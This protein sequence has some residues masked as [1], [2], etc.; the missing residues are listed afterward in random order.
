MQWKTVKSMKMTRKIIGEAAAIKSLN[1]VSTWN[2]CYQGDLSTR[3]DLSSNPIPEADIRVLM[4]H[5]QFAIWSWNP[6]HRLT[7][8]PHYMKFCVSW[9]RS[10]S[11]LSRSPPNWK[12]WLVQS[13]RPIS[14]ISRYIWK[15]SMTNFYAYKPG[16]WSWEKALR[17]S[18][19]SKKSKTLKQWWNTK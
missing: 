17:A 10:M 9:S 15:P 2:I 14:G 7:R 19:K 16:V 6:K 1:Q 12:K 8:T 18:R 5:S 3:E 13:I 11:Y 4:D